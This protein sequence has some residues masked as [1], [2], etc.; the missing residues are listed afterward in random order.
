LK[1]PAPTSQATRP[2]D[3]AANQAAWRALCEAARK[4][5]RD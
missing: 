3:P 1:V 5:P 4:L 2:G